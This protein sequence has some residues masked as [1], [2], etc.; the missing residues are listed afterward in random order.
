[1]FFQYSKTLKNKDLFSGLHLN[2]CQNMAS[3]L[4]DLTILLN[5]SV[6]ISFLQL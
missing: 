6:L 4:H 2:I 1:M 3:L 5:T